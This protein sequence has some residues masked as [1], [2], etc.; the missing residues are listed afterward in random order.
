MTLTFIRNG[1]ENKAYLLLGLLN[2]VLAKCH[3][4]T[5]LCRRSFP[6]FCS[7]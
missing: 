2:G 7:A 3:L 6:Y 4:V 5:A 1:A